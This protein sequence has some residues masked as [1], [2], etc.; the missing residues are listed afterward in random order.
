MLGLAHNER[1]WLEDTLRVVEKLKRNGT[2]DNLHS[3]VSVS[4][5]LLLWSRQCVAASVHRRLTCLV[6]IFALQAIKALFDSVSGPGAGAAAS[7]SNLL[8]PPAAHQQ[9]GLGGPVACA[10][11][12][13]FW[14]SKV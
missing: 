7:A 3:Q 14:A 12:L 10:R 6:Y 9:Q 1:N 11:P 4:T 13:Q 2:V 5:L 8:A